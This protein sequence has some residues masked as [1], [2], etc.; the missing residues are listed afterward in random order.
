[1]KTPSMSLTWMSGMLSSLSGS[2]YCAAIV[3][4]AGTPHIGHI[5]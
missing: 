5:P 3:R 2:D 1:V 4:P